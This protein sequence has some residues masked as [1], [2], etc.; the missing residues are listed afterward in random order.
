[1]SQSIF[2]GALMDVSHASR[3]ATALLLAA[4]LTPPA[5]VA[6]TDVAETCDG[7]VATIVVPPPAPGRFRTEPVTGTPGDDVI[8]GT[9]WPDTIDGAGGDDTICGLKGDDHLLGGSGRDRLFGGLDEQYEPDEGYEGDLI[10][11]GPG[12]DYVDLGYDMQS[13]DLDPADGPWQRWD[14]VSYLNSVGA[15]TVDLE[16][17]TAKGEGTDTIAYGAGIVGSAHDDVL[18]G[19]DKHDWI[20]AGGGDDLV[21]A[22]GGNDAVKT[23]LDGTSGDVTAPG[24]DV[25]V[26]GPGGDEIVAGHGSDR[27]FAGLGR[28]QVSLDEAA[29]SR[30]SGGAGVDFIRAG[31]RALIEGGRG[32]DKL[33]P[34]IGSRADRVRAAGGAGRDTLAIELSL[35]VAPHESHLVVGSPTGTVRVPGSPALVHFVSLEEFAPAGIA[36]TLDIT[37]YGTSGSDDLDLGWIEGRVRAFGRGG[38][39][40]LRGGSGSDHLDGGPGRDRLEGGSGDDVCL[41]GER[42]R[43]CEL[44]RSGSVSRS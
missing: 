10:E 40:W 29:G 15:V 19:S 33:S 42:L 7:K 34:R 27:V 11:P 31:G 44:R 17:G 13:D 28:D 2:D 9:A 30:V 35:E 43:S 4:A 25:V 16:A 26:G 24:D 1:M 6:A 41:R 12:N 20:A 37:W 23:D 5:A 32:A 39:D 18:L 8:V 14:R 21:D 36:V 38:N 3:A 22:R